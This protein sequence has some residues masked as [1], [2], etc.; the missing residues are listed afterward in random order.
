MYACLF[1]VCVYIVCLSR[2]SVLLHGLPDLQLQLPTLILLTAVCAAYTLH[3]QLYK[4]LPRQLLPYSSSNSFNDIFSTV[5][6]NRL[7][8]C[9]E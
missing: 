7:T 4:T 9:T 3:I 2:K 1:V 6:G 5:I 8:K